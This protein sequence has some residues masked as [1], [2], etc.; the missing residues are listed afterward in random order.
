MRLDLLRSTGVRHGLRRICEERGLARLHNVVASRYKAIWLDAA[1]EYGAELTELSGG[2]LEIRAGNA[3]TRVRNHLVML[4]D[5][6]TLQLSLQKAVVNALLSGAGLPVPESLEFPADDVS[7]A[8]KFLRAQ[9]G[10]C[11]VKPVGGSGGYA[12]TSAISDELDL[13]RARLRAARVDRRLVIERQVPGDLYRFLMLEGQLL[14][15]IRRSPPRVT[16]D[17]YSDIEA[18][19]AAENRRRVAQRHKA[20]LRPLTIDLE[21]ILTLRASG[22]HLRAIPPAGQRVAVK[23]VVNQNAPADNETVCEDV[24]SELVDAARAA[25]EVVGLRLAGVDLITTD[26]TR[27]LEASGGVILEVNGPPGLNY[28]YEVVNPDKARRVAIPILEAAM[29]G[30]AS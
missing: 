25:A 11:V 17:G 16:G 26:P 4:D 3:R 15:V 18:L 27:P 21:C 2:F 5:G 13:L 23:S 12:V 7:S 1:Q 10:P 20:L 8:I 9:R 30:G 29:R 22:L 24:C 28:H 6:L 14:D 19:I